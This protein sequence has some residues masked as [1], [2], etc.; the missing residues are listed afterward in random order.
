VKKN[1]KILVKL[2]TKFLF[3]KKK[4]KIITHSDCTALTL[5]ILVLDSHVRFFFFFFFLN[6]FFFKKKYVFMNNSYVFLVNIG[7]SRRNL[8]VK[9]VR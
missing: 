6:F 1:I 8:P 2:I 7:K 9:E 4:E 5:L 3:F